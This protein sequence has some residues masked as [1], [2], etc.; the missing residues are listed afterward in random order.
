MTQESEFQVLC[1][2]AEW[3]GTC[4]DYRDAFEA[5]ART[6]AGTRFRWLDIEDEADALGDLDVDNFPTLLIGRGGDVLFYGTMLP[7]ITH[8]ERLLETF[9]AQSPEESRAYATRGEERLAWQIN[10]DLR[11]LCGRD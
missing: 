2:C 9:Q 5:L 8:L 4:R 3:C 11:R 6:L 1:L 10:A 7:H